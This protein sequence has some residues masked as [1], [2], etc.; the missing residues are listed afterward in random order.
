M[1]FMLYTTW[2]LP[3]DIILLIPILLI[4]ILLIPILLIPILL[5]PSR[6]DY[7]V[8]SRFMVVTMIN[9]STI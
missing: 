7:V 6:H 9:I 5:I 8:L 4:P 2:N 1:Y 3:D